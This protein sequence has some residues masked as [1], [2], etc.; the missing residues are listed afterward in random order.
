MPDFLAGRYR[1]I[2]SLGEGGMGI[3]QL[4]EDLQKGGARIALK[5]ILPNVLDDEALTA[6]EQEFKVLARLQH[7][8]IARAYD[9]GTLPET[10][11][12]F[13]TSEFVEGKPLFE[14]ASDL[15]FDGR[16]DVAVQIARGLAYIHARGLV[17]H[18]IKANNVLLRMDS[19]EDA[20]RKDVH[21][22]LHSAERALGVAAPTPDRPLRLSV[23]IIDFGLVQVENRANESLAGAPAY[24]APEKIRWQRA[25]RRADLY[26]FGVLIYWLFTGGLPFTG[27]S[28]PEVLDKHLKAAPPPMRSLDPSLP[29]PLDAIVLRL[30][31]K[32]PRKRYDTATEFIEAVNH[33]LGRDFSPETD[34]ARAGYAATA[35]LVGRDDLLGV[36]TDA[37]DRVL[38]PHRF[39]VSGRSDPPAP[40]AFLLDGER[41][42]GRTRLIKEIR[43]YL[44][45]S[46]AHILETACTEE[47]AQSPAGLRTLLEHGTALAKSLGAEI[48]ERTSGLSRGLGKPGEGDAPPLEGLGDLLGAIAKRSPV[49]L[50]ADDLQHAGSWLWHALVSAAHAL[51]IARSVEGPERADAAPPVFIIG[52]YRESPEIGTPPLETLIEGYGA[53][54]IFLAL[55]LN[56][57]RDAEI[58]RLIQST[59]GRTAVPETFLRRMID[60]ARGNPQLVEEELQALADSGA[61]SI[62]S[63]LRVFIHS[64]DEISLT[65]GAASAL[66]RRL[67]ELAA[68]PRRL[69]LALALVERAFPPSCIADLGGTPEELAELRSHT[70]LSGTDE[71]GVRIA[72]PKLASRVRASA[73]QA[74]RAVAH[75]RIAESIEKDDPRPL[76]EKAPEIYRH[77]REAHE[78]V[79]ALPWALRAASLL[80]ARHDYDGAL[81]ILQEA[82][83]LV[84]SGDRALRLRVAGDILSLEDLRGNPEAY[85]KRAEEY[86]ARHGGDILPRQRVAVRQSLANHLLILGQARAAMHVVDTALPEAGPGPP[87][88]ALLVTRARALVR[89]GYSKEALETLAEI[90][91]PPAPEDHEALIVEPSILQAARLSIEIPWRAGGADIEPSA[92][93]AL[94]RTA[95]RADRGGEAAELR[96]LEGAVRYTRGDVPGARQS[97]QEALRL[98]RAGGSSSGIADAQSRLARIGLQTGNLRDALEHVREAIAEADRGRDCVEEAEAHLLLARLQGALGRHD[99]AFR[100]AEKALVRARSSGDTIASISA[101]LAA[102][103]AI[104]ALGGAAAAKPRLEAAIRAAEA[105]RLEPLRASGLAILGEAMFEGNDPAGG[106][107]RAESAIRIYRACR[108]PIEV[109]L[110]TERLARLLLRAGNAHA[111]AVPIEAFRKAI[112]PMGEAV[113][114]AR[115]ALLEAESAA[116]EGKDREAL[117][118][119]SAAEPAAEDGKLLPLLY[120]ILF[121]R[122]P[123]LSRSGPSGAGMEAKHRLQALLQSQEAVW[124]A[125]LWPPYHDGLRRE[126]YLSKS[127]ILGTENPDAARR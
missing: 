40:Q 78:P 50:L 58:R 49:A 123:I 108:R 45:V 70:L 17:H 44:L 52:T 59:F 54:G 71:T 26:A 124:E 41:G 95:Q 119:L 100:C 21:E 62:R 84:L 104:L 16:L 114:A 115:A 15:G 101:E 23:K 79:R 19:P 30:L 29:E 126:Y 74:D 14:A 33:G 92:L 103:E 117:E 97:L 25:D 106:I 51:S 47:D 125:E 94:A 43:T 105:A 66:G 82:E 77:Y 18:D 64:P 13:Y 67:D 83:G 69:L 81:R 93:D 72:H 80:R 11:E 37:F 56:P 10:G 6:F 8:N 76:E 1:V 89:S 68:G 90:P 96:L 35:P 55:G 4:V 110:A 60:I 122:I 99:R 73:T 65:E 87:R 91:K 12:H 57:L 102:C 116:L 75:R 2:R 88:H 53:Q 121:V 48:P 34:A 118:Q 24:L 5:R 20:V 109:A 32:E 113:L 120:R 39:R 28:L 7:P 31:E 27:D 85:V 86:L 9:F 107:V 3:V 63:G 22:D 36:M 112:E 42:M 38:R 46:G 98:H 111:A 61:L 127:R